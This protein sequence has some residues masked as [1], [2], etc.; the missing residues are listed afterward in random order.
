MPTLVLVSQCPGFTPKNANYHC[1]SVT[2]CPNGNV[3][4]CPNVMSITKFVIVEKYGVA[5]YIL[6]GSVL[7]T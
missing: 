7:F 5:T 6:Q 4:T 1:T 2:T 3:T